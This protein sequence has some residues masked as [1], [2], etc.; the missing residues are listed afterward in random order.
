MPRQRPKEQT[1]SGKLPGVLDLLDNC[2]S[3]YDA[4]TGSWSVD[5]A[6]SEMA[7]RGLCRRNTS[8]VPGGR[9][10]IAIRYQAMLAVKNAFNHA[11]SIY[12]GRENKSKEEKRRKIVDELDIAV[13]A[14]LRA[15]D[16]ELMEPMKSAV[17]NARAI[18]SATKDYLTQPALPYGGGVGSTANFLQTA[19]ASEMLRLW[20][21]EVQDSPRYPNK[22]LLV[23]LAVG[24]WID[25]KLPDYDIAPARLHERVK[26][27]FDEK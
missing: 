5:D 22:R 23:E 12:R 16:G 18:R 21:D 9:P 1:R 27:W 19:F 20:M 6:V 4:P 26:K 3:D 24:A 25:A 10:H 15:F 7:E 2:R 14:F 11:G 8:I 17:I 13:A